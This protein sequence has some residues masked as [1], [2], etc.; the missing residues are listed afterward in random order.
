MKHAC[1]FDPSSLPAGTLYPCRLPRSCSVCLR[2]VGLRRILNQTK[3]VWRG[4]MQTGG[5]G[6]NIDSGTQTW[7]IAH[8]V[9][10]RKRAYE[11]RQLSGTAVTC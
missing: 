11:H 5:G 7:D 6:R 2:S 1:K 4:Q 8:A 10:A 3:A 9:A